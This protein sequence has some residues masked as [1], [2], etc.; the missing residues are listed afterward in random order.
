MIKNN[1]QLKDGLSLTDKINMTRYI[2]GGYFVNDEYTPYYASI[3]KIVAFF[4]YCVDGLEFDDEEDVYSLSLSDAKLVELYNIAMMDGSPIYNDIQQ[5]NKDIDDMVD[6]YKRK[7]LISSSPIMMKLEE[8]LDKE[9]RNKDEELRLTKQMEK[10]MEENE[11]ELKASNEFTKLLTPEETAN[12]M[13]K[14]SND[15]FSVANLV[16]EISN[17]YIG[18][19]LHDNDMNNLLDEKNRKIEELQSLLNKK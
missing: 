12:I 5:V 2:V 11:K 4:R 15:D 17:K 19:S 10:V 13:R 14:F 16:S 6:F 3:N 9:S 1:I 7:L 18:Y 8:I